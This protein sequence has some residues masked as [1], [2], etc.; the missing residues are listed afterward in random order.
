MLLRICHTVSASCMSYLTLRAIYFTYTNFPYSVFEHNM[1]THP[2]WNTSVDCFQSI[3]VI[4][5]I[6]GT[7][8]LLVIYIMVSL[9]CVLTW[10]GKMDLWIL[11]TRLYSNSKWVKGNSL[12]SINTIRDNIWHERQYINAG[13]L[14]LCSSK[15]IHQTKVR[16]RLC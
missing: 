9:K 4:H 2:A 7:T 15:L 8:L 3:W 12:G 16:F 1:H 10:K 13:L 6:G 14:I 11:N 5:K